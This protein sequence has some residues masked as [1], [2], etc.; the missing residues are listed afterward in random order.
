MRRLCAAYEPLLIAALFFAV[1]TVAFGHVFEE[2]HFVSLPLPG[3]RLPVDGVIVLQSFGSV[4][5]WIRKFEQ[6]KPQLECGR[7]AINLDVVRQTAAAIPG[8]AEVTL[9][10]QKTPQPNQLCTLTVERRSGSGE[11]GRV[12]IRSDLRPD[13]SAAIPRS[14]SAPLSWLTYQPLDADKSSVPGWG[15]EPRVDSDFKPEVAALPRDSVPCPGRVYLTVPALPHSTETFVILTVAEIPDRPNV[16]E[17]SQGTVTAPIV[18]GHVAVIGLCPRGFG[19]LESERPYRASLTLI[20]SRGKRSK[21][22]KSIYFERP[23]AYE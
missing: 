6:T 8:I 12:I 15:A 17:P 23:A 10:P 19:R 21:E 14:E 16:E 13:G 18:R 11:T 4:P 22:S 20:D 5:E 3:G 7:E 2:L 1:P 9:R